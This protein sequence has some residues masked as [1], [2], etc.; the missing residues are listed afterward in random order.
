MKNE[1]KAG[2][3]YEEVADGFK[4]YDG[5]PRQPDVVVCRRLAD[6]PGERVPDGAATAQCSQCGAVIVYDP[7]CDTG[8]APRACMQCVSIEPL[9]LES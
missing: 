9:P 1:V 8:D 4:R 7:A 3:F 5:P 6:F 2:T